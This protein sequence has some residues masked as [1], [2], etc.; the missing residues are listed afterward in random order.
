MTIVAQIS[1]LHVKRE[2]RN[3]YRV[4]DTAATLRRVVAALNALTVQPD[5]VVASGDL[6]DG[7]ALEEYAHLERLLAPLR[8]PW[9]LAMGNHDDRTALRAAFPE[10]RYLGTEGPVQY[11]LDMLPLRIVV[12]DSTEPGAP[13]GTFDDVRLAWLEQTLAAGARPTLLVFHHPPFRTGLAAM[14]RKNFADPAIVERF[15]AIVRANPQVERIATGHLH[16]P[17]AVRWNGTVAAT[18]PSTAHQ[19]CLDFRPGVADSF[20]LEPPAYT[21]HVWDGGSLVSHTCTVESA[22]GPYPFREGGVLIE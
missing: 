21:L 2:G 18:V 16:R 1:D 6:V 7:G 8:A 15:G 9:Y 3:A 10:H 12:A 13:G 4:V 5:A 11:A 20:V 17:M 19:L 14:D 22:G